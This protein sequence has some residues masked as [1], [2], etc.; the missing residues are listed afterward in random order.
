MPETDG[1]ETIRRIRAQSQ[2]EQLP[3][4]ALT[5]KATRDDRQSCLEAGASDYMSKP[6]DRDQL[7]TLTFRRLVFRLTPQSAAIYAVF[8]LWCVERQ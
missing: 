8:S 1:L 5:A 4:I 3:I 2:Y 6:T 7:L